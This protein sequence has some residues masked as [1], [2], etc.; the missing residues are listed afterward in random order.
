MARVSPLTPS[1]NISIE[2]DNRRSLSLGSR[3]GKGTRASVFR[4]TIEGGSGVKRTVALKLFDVVASDEQE[5]VVPRIG[6]AIRNAALVRHPNVVQ[7][8]ECG[9][10]K[11]KQPFAVTELVEGRSLADL[12]DAYETA[13]Q[14]LPPD[15]ALFIGIEI[16]E[17]L[18]AA[19]GSVPGADGVVHGDLSA[20]DVLLSW[21]GE[22]KVTDFGVSAA[23]GAA[24][25]IRSRGAISKRL[26]TLAPEVAQGN[27]PD[28]RSDVFSL[29]ALL[30]VMLIGPRFA[31]EISDDD[32]MRK[33]GEG[34][35][36]R[37][38][39]GPQL[40]RDILRLI[41]RA[42]DPDPERR[43]RDPAVVAYELRRAALALGI[44]DGR[45]FLRHAMQVRFGADHLTDPDAPT[46]PSRG[47]A[48]GVVRRLK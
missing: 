48:R 9:V 25:A 21:Y 4:A 10:H 35:F 27:K 6:K 2:L 14:R 15:L 23:V 12:L 16:A 8:Y 34:H 36:E 38:L 32:T 42:T 31:R 37:P 29:G 17:G 33:A 11:A 44:G 28:T 41:D 19:H 45:V 22:V 26:V 39:F 3:V 40:P 5:V 1:S 30:Y 43:L 20:R 13:D 46:A 7:S 24:S 18:A 47:A